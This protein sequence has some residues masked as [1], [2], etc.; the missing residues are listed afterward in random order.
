MKKGLFAEK[1]SISL[2]IGLLNSGLKQRHLFFP[3]NHKVV[4]QT[5]DFDEVSLCFL[6]F[7]IHPI[8]HLFSAIADVSSY[9]YLLLSS[10]EFIIE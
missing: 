3:H 10:E 6:L 7:A 1:K 4:T 8:M 9:F 2:I 5:L